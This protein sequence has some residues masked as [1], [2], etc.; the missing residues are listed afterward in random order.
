M[1]FKFWK[2]KEFTD[3][4]KT[5]AKSFKD[6]AKALYKGSGSGISKHSGKILLATAAA[7]T[8]GG[9]ILSVTSSKTPQKN[10][11]VIDEK[12]GYTKA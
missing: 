7:S 1:T 9:I 11:N 3:S 10:V 12:N 5:F 2:G 4:M 6:S 8:I